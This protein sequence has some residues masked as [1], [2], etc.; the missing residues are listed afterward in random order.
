V[1]PRNAAKLKSLCELATSPEGD[2]SAKWEANSEV[3]TYLRQ[4]LNAVADLILAAVNVSSRPGG[5]NHT[6]LH[7]AVAA[8]P[9]LGGKK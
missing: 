3:M 9:K 5:I 8:L 1:T 4:N 2:A 7:E 6:R